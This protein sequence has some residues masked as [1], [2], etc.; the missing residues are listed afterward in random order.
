MRWLLLLIFLT[1]LSPSQMMA[2]SLPKAA[3]ANGKYSG[4]L[5]KMHCPTDHVRYGSFHDYG[6]WLGGA[7]CGQQ[8]LEGYLV[9][10]YPNWYVWKKKASHQS[11]KTQHRSQ[12]SKLSSAHGRY[13]GLMQTVNCPQDLQ[14]YGQYEDHGYWSG[15]DYCGQVTKSGYW[16]WAYPNWYIWKHKR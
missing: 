5:H 2:E 9:W 11:S 10:A 16:V 8:G 4:F 14:D 3:S 12:P 15:G 7:W 1:M 13:Y 6:Y